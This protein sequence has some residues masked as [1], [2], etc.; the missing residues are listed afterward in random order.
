MVFYLSIPRHIS[1]LL[2][3]QVS[4]PDHRTESDTRPFEP[5]REENEPVNDVEA[6]VAIATTQCEFSPVAAFQNKVA[7]LAE[8]L[9]TGL[10][11][12]FKIDARSLRTSFNFF[13]SI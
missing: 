13:A 4:I 9:S 11:F 10:H 12:G 5:K 1:L 6:A 8:V 3:S 7:Q 2:L